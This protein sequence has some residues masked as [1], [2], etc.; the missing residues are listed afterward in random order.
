MYAMAIEAVPLSSM[1]DLY[2]QVYKSP[3]RNYFM[4]VA[5]SFVGAI[6]LIGMLC[7]RTTKRIRRELKIK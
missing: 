1:E 3:H 6:F 7:G 5:F 4:L 2:Q